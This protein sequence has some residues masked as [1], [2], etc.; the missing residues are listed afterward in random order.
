MFSMLLFMCFMPYYYCCKLFLTFCSKNLI[1]EKKTY[2]NETFNQVFY[3][4]KKNS[5]INQII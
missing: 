5:L 4:Q 1:K 2:K 3:Q